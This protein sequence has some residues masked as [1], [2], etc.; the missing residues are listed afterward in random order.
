[1]AGQG[2]ISKGGKGETLVWV[3]GVRFG[4]GEKVKRTGEVQCKMGEKQ[5]LKEHRGR[6]GR[7]N[8]PWGYNDSPN[9]GWE[10]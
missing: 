9:C 6:G 2:H 4:V 1:M 5:K 7:G 3:L 10:V 8:C